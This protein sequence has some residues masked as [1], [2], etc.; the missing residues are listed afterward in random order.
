MAGFE[1]SQCKQFVELQI[2]A[3]SPGVDRE[4]FI[5]DIANRGGFAEFADRL[6]VELINPLPT[7]AVAQPSTPV[8]EPFMLFCLSDR[9]R[10]GEQLSPECHVVYEGWDGTVEVSALLSEA[11]D[12]RNWDPNPTITSFYDSNR[13]RFNETLQLTRDNNDAPSGEY[14]IAFTCHFTASQLNQDSWWYGTF[15]FRVTGEKSGELVISSEG[16]SVVNLAG[17]LD[18]LLRKFHTIRIDGSENALINIQSFESA[19]REQSTEECGEASKLMTIKLVRIKPPVPLEE[20]ERI[21][22]KC[23][24]GRLD[25]PNDRR[26]LV[27]A[28]N[29]V[30]MGSNRPNSDDGH[31]DIALRLFPRSETRDAL[32]RLIS[33]QHLEVTALKGQI[34]LRDPRGD[35][36]RDAVS[37]LANRTPLTESRSFPHTMLAINY[38]TSFGSRLS[39]SD[40]VPQLGLRI[41]SFQHAPGAVKRNQEKLE[42]ILGQRDFQQSWLRKESELDAVLIERV[43]TCDELNGREAYLLVMGCVLIGSD[44]DCLL[45]IEHPSIRP[46]HAILCHWDG[47]FRILPI[48]DALVV[49]DD[50][51]IHPGRIGTVK[52]RTT[53]QLGD[54]K[55]K[56]DDPVQFGLE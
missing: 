42:A 18:S 21:P 26:V 9:V 25:L 35:S 44:H 48:E 12:R 6:V 2:E 8:V 3:C 53:L 22:R 38:T 30:I 39:G 5:R 15:K 34:Q 27:Y 23:L 43:H 19:L 37:A 33:R 46:D 11:L 45:R 4:I 36:S 51:P 28:K 20:W 10:A 16:N 13:W 41:Q 50:Q 14:L 32:T 24:A 40:E 47:Q 54:L 1:Y 17:N 55:L 31:T 29:H 52:A 56:F 49:C 7:P